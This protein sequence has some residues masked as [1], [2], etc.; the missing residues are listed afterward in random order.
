MTRVEQDDKSISYSGNWFSNDSSANTGG[1]AVLTST[2]GARATLS[3]TGTGS[4]WIGVTDAGAGLANVYLDG[5]M[6][7]VDWIWL[8]GFDVVQ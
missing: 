4:T 5:T 7:I 8:D 3:F 6:K 1:K 2:R